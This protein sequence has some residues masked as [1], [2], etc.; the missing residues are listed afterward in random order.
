MKDKL[1][2]G[3]NTVLML[4]VFFVMF[5]FLWFV[6]ALL[7][8]NFGIHLGFELWLSLWQPLFTPAIGIL[9]GTTVLT[10]ILGQI[11]KRLQAS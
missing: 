1:L 6:V 2:K 10:G 3:L 11:F 4:N 9:M 5:S 8:N 7:G